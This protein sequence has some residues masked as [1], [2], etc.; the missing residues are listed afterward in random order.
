MRTSPFPAGTHRLTLDL[1]RHGMPEVPLVGAYE[2]RAS[3]QG[4]EWHRHEDTLEIC[5]LV[6]G[7]QTYH[8]AGRD[9]TLHAH[10]L[11]VTWPDV[12]HGTGHHP[13]GRGLL[14]WLQVRLPRSGGCLLG[15]DSAASRALVAALRSLPQGAFPGCPSLRTDFEGILDLARTPA[16]PLGRLRLGMALLRWLL[17]VLDAAAAPRQERPALDIARVASRLRA[18]PAAMPTV[19]EMAGWAGLSTS[20]FKAKFKEHTGLPPRD[21]LLRLKVAEA[22]RRLGAGDRVTAVA[23]DLGFA[24]SQHFATVFRRFR[25]ARPSTVRPLLT[26]RGASD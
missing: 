7:E 24:S 8:V 3:T 22:E 1:T 12:P 18:D 17:G 10:D 13:M 26:L 9:H 11:F 20:R 19:D 23:F 2:L 5:Y 6:R 21:F 16:T 4:L 14:Y 25:N 15:L